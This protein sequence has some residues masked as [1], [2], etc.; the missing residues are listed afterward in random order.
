MLDVVRS[1]LDEA[2]ISAW[3]ARVERVGTELGWPERRCVVRRHAGGVLLAISAPADQLLLATE[4]NEWALCA[5]LAERDPQRA[6]S[7]GDFLAG[8]GRGI[9]SR[10]LPRLGYS[11][12]PASRDLYLRK[13]TAARRAA[14]F[15]RRQD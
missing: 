5:A 12:A 10:Q 8:A 9:I 4:V 7:L 3:R 11:Y 15:P 1:S 6:A 14:P 13:A 2:Q